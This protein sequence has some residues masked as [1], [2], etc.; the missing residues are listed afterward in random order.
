MTSKEEKALNDMHKVVVEMRDGVRSFQ[1]SVQSEV[2]SLK[3][4][5][6]AKHAPLYF[7]KDILSVAQSSI[8][9]SI[10]SQLSGYNSP[11]NKLILS[12][13]D[14]HSKELRTIIDDAFTTVIRTDEF[15]QSIVSAFSHK[16][17]RSIISNNEGLFDK[18]SNDL[19][20]D[21]QFK[22][23]MTLAVAAVVEECL[24]DKRQ[25]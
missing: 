25:A 14:K 23:R 17:S 24:K 22:A 1:S 6:S 15:K 18:V 7:E 21:N 12:V 11:L 4:Q 2:G 13:V 3:E 8:H 19:K 9:E 16:V 5:V 10:K 20:Q